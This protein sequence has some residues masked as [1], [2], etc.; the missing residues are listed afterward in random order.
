MA[1][2]Q[3]RTFEAVYGPDG[4][5]LE[6]RLFPAGDGIAL[7]YQDVTAH[8]AVEEN[9]ERREHQQESVARLGLVALDSAPIG[10]LLDQA[11]RE[12]AIGL[13]TEFS[14]FVEVQSGGTTLLLRAGV[15]WHP[16]LVGTAT[17]PMDA[18]SQSGYALQAHGPVIVE[19]LP[20]DARFSAPPLLL[21][22]GVVSGLSVLVGPRDAP[23]GVL[24][25]HTAVRRRF[26]QDDLNF[27]QAV[28][29]LL[30]A[31]ISRHAIETELRRHRANLEGLVRDRT[32]L[33]EQ[34]N[35][36]LEAFSYSVSHDLRTPLRAI[37]GFSGLLA[38][39]YGPSLPP[40]AQGLLEKVRE[41]AQRMGH[42]I[43]SLLAL[44]RIGRQELVASPIDVSRVATDV[45]QETAA[46]DPDRRVQWTVQ[47]GL[48]AEGDPNL[49]RALLDNLLGNAW[50]FTATRSK[51]HIEVGQVADGSFFVRDDGAGFDPQHASRLFEPFQRLHHTTQFEGTGVGLA[52][53]QR[54]AQRHGGTVWAESKAGKGATF[55]FTL[56]HAAAPVTPPA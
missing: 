48:M 42:L 25:A 51:A 18:R 13:G 2:R 44:A 33:L 7:Y 31:A 30:G 28:A 8:Q 21:E 40:A 9:L 53:V 56:A 49:V 14:K 12:V 34:S 50:K 15:G 35:R 55:W 46:R 52:I 10:T 41:G 26:D 43:E 29:N 16:G 45:L 47:P 38:R 4:V 23:L 22:H 11:V 20:H 19:D 36:E 27:L 37:D 24:G 54:I 17:V 6:N 3:P 5:R 32:R 1:D 39:Q